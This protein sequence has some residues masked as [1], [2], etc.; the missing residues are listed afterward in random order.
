MDGMGAMLCCGMGDICMLLLLEV[1]ARYEKWR[2]EDPLRHLSLWCNQT[3][4]GSCGYSSVAFDGAANNPRL[5]FKF[6]SW[7]RLKA[8]AGWELARNRYS[9]GTSKQRPSGDGLTGQPATFTLD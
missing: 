5:A 2:K 3:A 6:E 8:G 1:D 7:T 9:S 4:G